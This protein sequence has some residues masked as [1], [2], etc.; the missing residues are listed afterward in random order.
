MELGLIHVYTG[1]GKGKTTAAI[2]QMIR[3]LGSGLKI[4]FVQFLK[5]DDTGETGILSNLTP[6]VEVKRFNTQKKF[7]WNM[8]PE[9]IEVLKNDSQKGYEY[10]SNII[11]ENSCDLL[12]LDEFNWVLNKNFIDLNEFLYLLKNKPAS[13]EIIITGRNAPSSLIE[14]AD[15]VTEMK[16]IKHPMDKGIQARPGIER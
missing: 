6:P 10:I 7:I 12:V 5:A 13:M 4:I 3:S 16:K 8:K 9:E 1:E 2:G 15:Y 14:M 11:T